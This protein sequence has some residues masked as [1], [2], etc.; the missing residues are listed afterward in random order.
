MYADF[1]SDIGA[2]VHH[3]L[4]CFPEASG[5]APHPWFVILAPKLQRIDR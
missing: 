5:Q 3:S 4:R 2:K 1:F